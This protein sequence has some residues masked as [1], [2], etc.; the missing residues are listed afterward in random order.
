MGDRIGSLGKEINHSSF[1]STT[2][3]TSQSNLSKATLPPDYYSHITQ[4]PGQGS[5]CSALRTMAEVDKLLADIPSLKPVLVELRKDH[6]DE[7]ISA[8]FAQA[9]STDSPE[10]KDAKDFCKIYEDTSPSADPQMRKSMLKRLTRAYR[11]AY[12]ENA[13]AEDKALDKAS[14]AYTEGD[15]APMIRLLIE[16]GY[17]PDS[18][19]H[20]SHS[21]SSESESPDYRRNPAVSSKSVS[22]S[23]ADAPTST[24]LKGARDPEST[25][26]HDAV[27]MLWSFTELLPP[28]VRD[29]FRGK[30]KEGKQEAVSALKLASK[31]IR[32]DEKNA[33]KLSDKVRVR[34]K[35]IHL[36]Q[37]AF[38]LIKDE[39]AKAAIDYSDAPSKQE[40]FTKELE[41]A[42]LEFL[43][44]DTQHFNKF[45]NKY[46]LMEDFQPIL[47]STIGKITTENQFNFEEHSAAKV[48]HKKAYAVVKGGCAAF[49]SEV[50]RTAK[51]TAMKT[52]ST[53]LSFAVQETL[54]SIVLGIVLSNGYNFYVGGLVG[55]VVTGIYL[56]FGAGLKQV[57]EAGMN[58]AIIG[59]TFAVNKNQRL[60][61]RIGGEYIPNAI[62]DLAIA[63][64]G[65]AIAGTAGFKAEH[66]F[67]LYVLSKLGS[68]VFTSFGGSVVDRLVKRGMRNTY[69]PKVFGQQ[70]DE[71]MFWRFSRGART[72]ISAQI[73]QLRGPDRWPTISRF[74]MNMILYQLI[75]IAVTLIWEFAS[76]DQE[77]STQ[78]L[79]GASDRAGRAFA[80]N[81]M[82]IVSSLLLVTAGSILWNCM[83]G[84]DDADPEPVDPLNVL[85]RLEDWPGPGDLLEDDDGI[86]PDPEAEDD[87][88]IRSDYEV[89]DE[90][91]YNSDAEDDD[92]YNSDADDE[93]SES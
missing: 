12:N 13:S 15:Y 71:A 93:G 58:A 80:F 3:I 88:G 18:L 81:S 6:R 52:V 31:A 85:D 55:S 83:D 68:R 86:Q 39:L 64:I 29:E 44:G 33:G 35:E 57:L 82:Y 41:V 22:R 45:L 5:N 54:G 32:D 24:N 91:P 10:V 63:P 34:R 11:E 70:P 69:I 42:V 26:E 2:P 75:N 27:G 8:Y 49:P 53:A 14:R 23:H 76:P 37:R 72:N 62:S 59:E 89:D 38:E 16:A 92:A 4:K 17:T 48:G 25:P 50:A 65:E 30:L 61:Y 87:D 78:Y 79:S 47:K 36:C 66:E 40:A 51:Y 20:W 43:L 46:G 56:P 19:K 84:S 90:Y 1:T 67:F 28:D 77:V 21:H 74:A 9:G 60:I 73:Q 7:A